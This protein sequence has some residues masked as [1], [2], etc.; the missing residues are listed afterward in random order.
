MKQQRAWALL[1]L[2]AVPGL[3]SSNYLIARAAQGVIA[4]HV[5]ALGR[6]AVAL[7]VMLPFVWHAL[8]TA[9]SGWWRTEWR[10]CLVLGALG[11]WVC[12]AWVYIGGQSTSAMN[13]GLIYAAAP[14]GIAVVG[15]WLGHE[16]LS[17]AKWAAMAMALGGVLWVISKGKP[18]QLLGLRLN[19]G[20]AWVMGAS[21]AWVA[22]SVLLARWKSALAPQ[23]RLAVIVLGGLI[24]MLPFTVLELALIDAPPFS[25]KAL[26]LVLAAALLPGAI[27]Y[28]AHSYVQRELGV[29]RTALMLYLAPLYAAVLAWW[30]L[31]EPPQ[32]YHAFGAALILPSIWLAT[33][34]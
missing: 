22:Y 34:R 20:D 31:G 17:A 23:A 19:P 33:R 12:G 27:S 8:K 10:Q 9:P 2:W 25:G 4:P 18:Q 14:V 11:M 28:S 6:W 29:A 30:L 26:A 3:W 7:A 5:L 15:V 32:A 24:V 13:I 21:A 16:R 1:M